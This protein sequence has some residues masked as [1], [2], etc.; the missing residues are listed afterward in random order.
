MHGA[1]LLSAIPPTMGNQVKALAEGRMAFPSGFALKTPYW[2]N[3]LKMVSQ[4]DPNFDA[5]NYNA[6]SKTRNWITSGQGATTVTA[7]NTALGH[8]A[9][10]A[11]NFDKLGNTQFPMINSALNF[12]KTQLGNAQPTVVAFDDYTFLHCV[13]C[14]LKF[15]FDLSHPPATEG[16]THVGLYGITIWSAHS[17]TVWAPVSVVVGTWYVVCVFGGCCECVQSGSPGLCN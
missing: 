8:A 17:A 12:G 6:R 4:Y 11:D 10:L 1:D 15:L 14:R 2:Q 7:L 16:R 13:L 5:V 9:G 3:M